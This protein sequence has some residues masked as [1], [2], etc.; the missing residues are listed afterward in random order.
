MYKSTLILTVLAMMFL[1]ACAVVPDVPSEEST[2]EMTKGAEEIVEEAE[3]EMNGK[4]PFAAIVSVDDPI[5]LGYTEGSKAMIGKEPVTLFFHAPWCPVYRAWEKEL[6]EEGGLD[7]LPNGT[8]LIKVDYDTNVDLRKK[9]NVPLQSTLVVL[10]A[11][12]NTVSLTQDP[13]FEDL[14]KD[15]TKSLQ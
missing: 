1:S 6:L 15:I 9:Y 5:Y 13:T 7:K 3:K 10:D 8:K 14:A 12:G 4:E 11:E 2:K